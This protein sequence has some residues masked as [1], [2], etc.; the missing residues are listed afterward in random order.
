[1]I[2]LKSLL[3]EM[4]GK[5]EVPKEPGTEPIPSN[6]LRLYHYTMDVDPEVLKREGLLQS[7]SRGSTYGEPNVVWA[8][9]QL[10]RRHKMFVEFSMAIDDPRFAG[11]G[12][13]PDVERGVAWYKGRSNDFAIFGDIKP[14]EFIA[15]HEP[16]HYTYRYMTE[17]RDLIDGILKGE[18]DHLLTGHHPDEAKAILA[19]KQNFGK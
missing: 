4:V 10:P 2:K 14:S 16:W 1:M 5:I 3:Q 11:I 19:I 15:I 6:H 8:S 9:L 7:K 18:Y 17:T 12:L 13:R